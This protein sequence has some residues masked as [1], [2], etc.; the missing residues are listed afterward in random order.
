[1]HWA[2]CTGSLPPQI[3]KGSF[4]SGRVRPC[5]FSAIRLFGTLNLDVFDEKKF[6]GYGPYGYD[7]KEFIAREQAVRMRAAAQ[8]CLKGVVGTIEG[9]WHMSGTP[10]CA[11]TRFEYRDFQGVEFP[12]VRVGRF[13]SRWITSEWSVIRPEGRSKV[14]RLRDR[15]GCS[16]GSS[17]EPGVRGIHVR[18]PRAPMRLEQTSLVAA[19]WEPMLL[20]NMSRYPLSPM[21]S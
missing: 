10:T 2:F 7:V 8:T 16:V 20:H 18:L 13:S 3:W 9:L 1:M 17:S 14:F 11:G 4:K 21:V 19:W 6:R 12:L 15:I 5:K